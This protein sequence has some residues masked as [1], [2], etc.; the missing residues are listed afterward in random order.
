MYLLIKLSQTD[1]KEVDTFETDDA[2]EAMAK[3]IIWE[4]DR[5][6]VKIEED[7]KLLY[8]SY[9]GNIKK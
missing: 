7:G 8:E 6:K 5:F 1:N 2:G 9:T 4:R 3:K